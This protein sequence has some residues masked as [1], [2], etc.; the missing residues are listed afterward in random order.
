VITFATATL[1][2]SPTNSPTIVGAQRWLALVLLCAVHF[3]VVLGISI[4]NIA[5][6]SVEEDL[7]FSGKCL[8]WVVSA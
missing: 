1:A 6:P 4:V 5:P 8:Q 3:I 2:Q 7:G